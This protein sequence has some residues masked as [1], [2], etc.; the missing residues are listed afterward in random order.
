[1]RERCA[2]ASPVTFT[3]AGA[4]RGARAILPI[5]PGA[6]AFGLVYGFLAGERGLSALEI[7]LT[8][9]L[10]FAGASQFLALELWGDPLPL[11]GLVLGVLVINLRHLLMGPALLPWLATIPPGAGLLQP[12]LHDRRGLGRQRR[13]PATWRP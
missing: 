7:G 12:L 1:M 9:M 2:S 4:A 10:V 3:L 11:A 5:V 13:G 8:S 6:V